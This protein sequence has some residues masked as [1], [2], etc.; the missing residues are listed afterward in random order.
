MGE[1]EEEDN[2]VIVAAGFQ[3][4]RRYFKYCPTTRARTERRKDP[5]FYSLSISG[6]RESQ[7]LSVHLV[8]ISFLSFFY[9]LEKIP[10]LV[11]SQEMQQTTDEQLSLSLSS[12]FRVL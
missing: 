7:C 2:I 8:V 6:R 4:E 1:K 11:L 3:R 12:L 9:Q 10:H 5:S